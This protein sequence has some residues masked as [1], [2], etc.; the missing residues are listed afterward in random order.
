VSEIPDPI[1]SILPSLVADLRSTLGDD[2][3]AIWLYGSAV[4]GGFDADSSDLDLVVVTETEAASLD[5]ARLG[6]VHDRLTAREPDWADRL[7]LAYVDRRTLA[8]F[9]S[10]GPVTSISHDEPLQVYDEADAWLQTWYLVR[11][12]DTTILGPSPA[13]LIPEIGRREFA[14]AVAR[15]TAELVDRARGEARPG[16]LA[17]L[18]LTLPRVLLTVEGG[19]V[20]SKQVA[21]AEVGRRWPQWQPLLQACL[22]VRAARGQRELQRGALAALPAFVTT[23]SAAIRKAG[24]EDA[25]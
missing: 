20:V 2:L 25:G 12:A 9:R 5:L 3:V 16:Y 18:C 14:A 7:D 21:A 8:T 11:E 10:G 1:A 4:M 19:D 22:A 24:A 6:S 17:Y 23:I 13:A 15:T